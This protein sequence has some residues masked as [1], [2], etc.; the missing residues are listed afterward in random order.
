[1]K[2]AVELQLRIRDA[3]IAMAAAMMPDERYDPADDPRTEEPARA[4][5]DLFGEIEARGII[6][7]LTIVQSQSYLR[8]MLR[9]GGEE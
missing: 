9:D 4:L 1:M 3:I 6:E 5:V 7:A 8:E 2:D